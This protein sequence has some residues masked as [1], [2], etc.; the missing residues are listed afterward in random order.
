MKGA[1]GNLMIQLTML[2]LFSIFFI[3]ITAAYTP[4]YTWAGTNITD[5]DSNNTVAI[6]NIMWTYWPI[7]IIFSFLIYMITRTQREERVWP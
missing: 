1:M 6:I 5:P 7:A 2:G 4:I 3:A